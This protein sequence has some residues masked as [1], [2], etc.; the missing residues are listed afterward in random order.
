MRQIRHGRPMDI[1]SFTRTMRMTRF[2]Y[3]AT[4]AKIPACWCTWNKVKSQPNYACLRTARLSQ[5]QF[6]QVWEDPLANLTLQILAPGRYDNSQSITRQRFR[7]L[8]RPTAA[9][10][11]SHR[12]GAAH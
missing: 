1:R 8:G 9:S 4:P 6:D 5:W 2:G 10:S 11:I 7:L 12:A 3:A